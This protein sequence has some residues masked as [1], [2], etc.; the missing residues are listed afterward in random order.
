MSDIIIAESAANLALDTFLIDEAS[1]HS[2]NPSTAGDNELSGVGYSRQS[3]T[4][5]TAANAKRLLQDDAVFTVT[6]GDTV[7]WISYWYQGDFVIARKLITA[8]EYSQSGTFTLSADTEL[9][10]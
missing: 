8:I 9:V 4:F 1:L 2:D 10:L 3:V 5:L 7:A 6:A